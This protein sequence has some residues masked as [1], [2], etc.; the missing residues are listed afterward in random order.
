[1]NKHLFAKDIQR[2]DEDVR[3]HFVVASKNISL[4]RENKKFLSVTLKDKSGTIEGR[5]WEESDVERFGGVFDKGDI[6]YVE[7]RSSLFQGKAQLKIRNIRRVDSGFTID[8]MAK[9]YRT[10]E[11]P[12]EELKN[13]FLSLIKSIA[14]DDIRRLFSLFIART[15]LAERFYTYPA[16]VG[17]HHMYI[18]GLLE[19]SLSVAHTAKY[20]AAGAGADED[21]IVAGSLLHDIG[22]IEELEFRGGFVYSDR[23]RLL[24]HISLGILILEE[25]LNN[26]DGFPKEIADVLSHIII[27]HHGTEEWGSP[28]KPMCIEALIIHYIDNLDAK[29]MGVKEHMLDKM[30][31]ER[32]TEY[33]RLYESRFYKIPGR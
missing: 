28:R 25:L 13:N 33:H 32:W 7:S 24:G 10:S 21:I 6:V 12:I 23:G 17:V 22:K 18:G 19:H 3:D 30:E 5:I 15:E 2:A 1:M 20:A 29:V 14:N 8:D 4:T 9:F 16:S 11:K 26:L 27:S 31:D